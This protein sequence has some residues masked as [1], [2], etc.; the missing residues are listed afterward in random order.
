MFKFKNYCVYKDE[1]S[2][3]RMGR[4]FIAPSGCTGSV[5]ANFTWP[6]FC[7]APRNPG[8]ELSFHWVVAARTF[9]CKGAALGVGAGEM[10]FAAGRAAG[11]GEEVAL[12]LQLGTRSRGHSQEESRFSVDM[13]PRVRYLSVSENFL[14]DVAFVKAAVK[15]WQ[16]K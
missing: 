16:R 10:R 1:L 2:R 5:F 9:R 6:K 15:I 12:P 3:I 4:R 14:R 8:C 11:A 13:K 7:K